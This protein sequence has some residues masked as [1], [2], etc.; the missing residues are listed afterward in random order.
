MFV[1]ETIEFNKDAIDTSVEKFL[2]LGLNH[3]PYETITNAKYLIIMDH[4]VKYLKTH[5]DSKICEKLQTKDLLFNFEQRCRDLSIMSSPEYEVFETSKRTEF[6]MLI[7]ISRYYAQTQRALFK[8]WFYIDHAI[9][10][11]ENTLRGN[12]GNESNN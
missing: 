11:Y 6:N 12:N 3:D 1:T 8:V 2:L 7:P 9:I 5:N 10:E 4:I